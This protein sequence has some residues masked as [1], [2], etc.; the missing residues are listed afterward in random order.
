MA[1]GWLALSARMKRCTAAT[2]ARSRLRR[3]PRLLSDLALLAQPSVLAL[4]LAQAGALVASQ[5]LGLAGLDAGLMDPVAK[6]LAQ[7]AELRGDL[8]DRLSRRADEA[9]R[10]SSELRWIR[11]S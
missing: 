3:R 9:D 4:E 10:L 8:R 11:R 5:A 6:R 2:S 1:T 7:D